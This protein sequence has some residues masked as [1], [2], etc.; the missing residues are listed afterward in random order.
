MRRPRNFVKSSPYFWLYVLRSKVRWRFCKIL[1]PSQNIWTLKGSNSFFET[2]QISSFFFLPENIGALSFYR[3]RNLQSELSTHQ[4]ST[5][6]GDIYKGPNLGQNLGEKNW[7]LSVLICAISQANQQKTLH[8]MFRLSG[9]LSWCL[10]IW[11]C[12]ESIL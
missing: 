9:L 3:I 10:V 11:C 7:W 6:I 4:H 2:R 8:Q 12:L 5:W 1:W